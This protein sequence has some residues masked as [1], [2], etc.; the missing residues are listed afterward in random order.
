MGRC[1]LDWRASKGK[2]TV[3]PI[4]N[5]GTVMRPVNL[6]GRCALIGVLLGASALVAAQE[7]VRDPDWPRPLPE[8]IEWGQVPNVTIGPQGHIYAFHRSSPPVLEFDP[9]GNLVDSWDSERIHRPHGFRFAP[10]GTIWATDFDRENGNQVLQFNAEGELLRHFGRQGVTGHS[11]N[12]FDG[13]ADVAVA[14]NGDIFVADGHWNNRIV[15]YD[16]QG[17]YLMEWGGEGD[18]PGELNL[19]HSIVIDQRGRVLVADRGNHRI[20]IFDQNGRYLDQWTQFGRPSGLF[21][22]D[23]DILYVADYQ[24]KKGVTYG[25]AEDGTVMGFI[26]GTEP[27]GVVV[28]DAGNVY[29][30]EVI[31]GDGSIVKKFVRRSAD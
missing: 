16:A 7:Y 22:D 31:G 18:G 21:I 12:L 4:K 30:G 3:N 27:E 14:E 1:Q 2:L 26:D 9:Q 15:K 20:Q 6:I 5:G 10:D 29:T 17:N 23:D 8:D 13:P 24:E 19:P 25:S 11:E 28:D